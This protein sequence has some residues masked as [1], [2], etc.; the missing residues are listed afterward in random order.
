MRIQPRKQMLARSVNR[1]NLILGTLGAMR[2]CRDCQPL[3]FE[4]VFLKPT[5]WGHHLPRART[6]HRATTSFNKAVQ[7]EDAE[8]ELCPPPSPVP[9]PHRPMETQGFHGGNMQ[10]TAQ[11]GREAEQRTNRQMVMR[12]ESLLL[13]SR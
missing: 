11:E 4:G 10:N 6:L 8:S 9:C 2:L 13:F 12:L 5:D 3:G 7:R 1:E